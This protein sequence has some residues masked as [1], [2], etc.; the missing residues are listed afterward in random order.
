MKKKEE[1]EGK[2]H[3]TMCQLKPVAVKLHLISASTSIYAH[4]R[5]YISLEMKSHFSTS[6][7]QNVQINRNETLQ[8]S[9][10]I[11]SY[12]NNN[13]QFQFVIK[14][15]KCKRSRINRKE[16]IAM[17]MTL[18]G[19]RLAHTSSHLICHSNKTTGPI[20][21]YILQQIL[22]SNVSSDATCQIKFVSCSCYKY[23]LYITMNDT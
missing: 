8:I 2:K 22:M 6:C 13:L 17:M 10:W 21:K 3:E 19:V 20:R 7:G 4:I 12:D 15:E 16:K 18:Y 11:R 14:N 5:K 1:E 9:N 23:Y